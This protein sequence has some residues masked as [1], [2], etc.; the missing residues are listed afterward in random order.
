[1]RLPSTQ[2]SQPKPVAEAT[3]TPQL[4]PDSSPPQAIQELIELVQSMKQQQAELRQ[5]VTDVENRLT[6][7]FA[8]VSNKLTELAEIAGRL[9][10][11]VA[12][13]ADQAQSPFAAMFSEVVGATMASVV[14]SGVLNRQLQVHIQHDMDAR[15]G[16][17]R[18]WA[19]AT[20]VPIQFSS[21]VPGPNVNAGIGPEPAVQN[22]R[23]PHPTGSPLSPATHPTFPIESE[24]RPRAT[25]P[26]ATDDDLE[27]MLVPQVMPHLSPSNLS[28][29][30][31]DPDKSCYTPQN[32]HRGERGPVISATPTSPWY[33]DL[34]ATEECAIVDQLAETSLN[35]RSA[36]PVNPTDK[37]AP[38]KVSGTREAFRSF[39]LEEDILSAAHHQPAGWR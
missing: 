30:H 38:Q 7:Q 39:D 16:C 6:N 34:P 24:G 20:F 28:A 8:E 2:E 29:E 36:L 18:D 12:A 23:D 4:S 15:V 35:D 1:M 33:A 3:S 27:S 25:V 11:F 14:A 37:L 22:T 5:H 10:S 13:S 19:R 21:P 17:I 9:N 32:I 31:S 26:V